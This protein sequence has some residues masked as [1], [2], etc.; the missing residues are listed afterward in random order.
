MQTHPS[1]FPSHADP[2]LTQ[3]EN[4][5]GPIIEYYFRAFNTKNIWK[6][7]HLSTRQRSRPCLMN[8]FKLSVIKI[9]MA[10]LRIIPTM[11]SYLISSILCSIKRLVPYGPG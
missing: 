1:F 10:Q 5:T 7:Q 11:R 8:G 6:I 4:L 9:S 3:V 2:P